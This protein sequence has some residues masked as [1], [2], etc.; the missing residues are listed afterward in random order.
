MLSPLSAHLLVSAHPG[1]WLLA[2]NGATC[3]LDQLNDSLN[4]NRNY[5]DMPVNV[6]TNK[7]YNMLKLAVDKMKDTVLLARKVL[8]ILSAY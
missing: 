3:S 1:S 4:W 7:K 8:G 6:S 5:L 2:L